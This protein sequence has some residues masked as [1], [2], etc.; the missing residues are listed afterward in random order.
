MWNIQMVHENVKNH[1]WELCGKDFFGYYDMKR[2][3]D[4][5]HL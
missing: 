4:S 1:K 2:H 5:V 3:I